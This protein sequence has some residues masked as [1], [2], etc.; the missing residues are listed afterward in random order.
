L[1]FQ[2]EGKL[3]ESQEQKTIEEK[4][5][6]EEMRQKYLREQNHLIH[7]ALSTD[8]YWLQQ[9]KRTQLVRNQ[10]KDDLIELKTYPKFTRENPMMPVREHPHS[11]RLTPYGGKDGM[12]PIEKDAVSK[13]M[14]DNLLSFSL[15]PSLTLYHPHNSDLAPV[16]YLRIF[17]LES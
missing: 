5:H 12:M 14:T 7:T 10:Y 15:S 8:K 1:K 17:E 13:V 3:R 9:E 6:R 16:I 11:W 4:H 2:R